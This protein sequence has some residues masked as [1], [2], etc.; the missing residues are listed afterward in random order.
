MHVRLAPR[1]RA[2]SHYLNLCSACRIGM[3][4]YT[5]LAQASAKNVSMQCDP[6]SCSPHR[7]YRIHTL[8]SHAALFPDVGCRRCRHPESNFTAHFSEGVPQPRCLGRRVHEHPRVWLL[9]CPSHRRKKSARPFLANGRRSSSPLWRGRKT[10]GRRT[11]GRPLSTLFT[12]E[13]PFPPTASN[14]HC[15]MYELGHTRCGPALDCCAP[16]AHAAWAHGGAI[17]P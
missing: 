15:I 6:S 11:P 17:P 1:C 14:L 13:R 12:S 9:R 2:S 3:R 16:C 7:K 5:P 4:E 8:R 10:L